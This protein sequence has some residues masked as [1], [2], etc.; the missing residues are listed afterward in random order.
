VS[1]IP[2]AGNIERFERNKAIERLERF[3]FQLSQLRGGA[4]GASHRRQ[5]P[6]RY[7]Q[8]Q[9]EEV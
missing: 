2:D 5:K 6:D 9:D 7:Q 1:V 3:N 8:F 4:C